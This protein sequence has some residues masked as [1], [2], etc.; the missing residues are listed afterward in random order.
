MLHRLAALFRVAGTV[1]QEQTV[2]LQL[3]EVVVPRYA[4]HFYTTLDKATDD[5]GLYATIH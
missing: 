2:E 1:S 3:V 4:N 5:I